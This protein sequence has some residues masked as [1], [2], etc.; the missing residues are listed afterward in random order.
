MLQP[1]CFKPAVNRLNAESKIWRFLDDASTVIYSRSKRVW[2]VGG[3]RRFPPMLP[4]APGL[5]ICG[6]IKVCP[7][8]Q[9]IIVAPG[10]PRNKGEGGG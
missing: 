4:D 10:R 9:T 3:V 6:G 1:Y 8:A 2:D 7:T 5:L